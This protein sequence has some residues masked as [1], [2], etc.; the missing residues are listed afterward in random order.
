[1]KIAVAFSLSLA[2]AT[3]VLAADWPQYH[4]PNLNSIA[5]EVL[6]VKSF[7]ASGPAEVWKTQTNLGFSSFVVSDGKALTIEQRDIDGN[8]MEAVVARN[9]ASGEEL[10]T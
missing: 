4:G 3:S 10:W 5:D 1:M 9:A 6:P 8:N 7:P 2:I